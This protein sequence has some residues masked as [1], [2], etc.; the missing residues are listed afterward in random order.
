VAASS[1]EEEGLHTQV[2]VA[3]TLEVAYHTQVEVASCEVGPLHHT[4][5][6]LCE[7]SS[8]APL[9]LLTLRALPLLL[10]QAHACALHLL[11]RGCVCPWHHVP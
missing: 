9:A 4:L 7:A 5:S 6:H 1:C 10:R 2:E 11:V 8:A 3:R